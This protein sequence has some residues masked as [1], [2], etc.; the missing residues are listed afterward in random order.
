MGPMTFAGSTLDRASDRRARPEWVE[1]ARRDQ[2]GRAVLASRRG[3]GLDGAPAR[4]GDDPWAAPEGDRLAPRLVEPDDREPILLGV[5]ADGA[6]LWVLEATDDEPLV[7]LREAAPLLAPEDAGLLAHAQQLVHFRHTHAFC[8]TCGRPTA[9]AEAGHLRVCEEGHST[10]PRTDPVVIMLVTDGADHV[11]MG[12]QPSWP[13]G[14]YSALA[15]FVE[16]GESLEHAVAREVREEAAIEVAD[17]RYHASQPWPFPANLML[18]FYATYAGGDAHADDDE[19]E[20]VRWFSR[21][22]ITAAA[23]GGGEQGAFKLPP[24][25]AIARRLI[26][27]WLAA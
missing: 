3:V 7:G 15:G 26:D 16:P 20:D 14:R 22:E 12:R 24:P 6:P 11:L 2:R 17:V 25:M 10:H 27:G 5:R 13:A 4:S 8:G 23:D 9:A 18:G 19:L 21:T 1:R